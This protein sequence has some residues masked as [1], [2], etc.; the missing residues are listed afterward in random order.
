MPR[1]VPCVDPPVGCR[2]PAYTPAPPGGQRKANG[3]AANGGA[4]N[5]TV[6][7]LGDGH[8]AHFTPA[9]DYFGAAGFTYS[10]T[11]LCGGSHSSNS[12]HYAGVTIDVGVINGRTVAGGHQDVRDFMNL[13]RSLGATEVL[14]PGNANHDHHVHAGWPRP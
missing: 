6:T 7:L 2:T 8:T 11:E 3:G 14:G 4:T 13:C 12:R 1:G 9:A 5:G 10:V